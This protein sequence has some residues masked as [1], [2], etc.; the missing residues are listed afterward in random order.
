ML[1][2][3]GPPK[4]SYRKNNHINSD[5]NDKSVNLF[6]KSSFLLIIPAIASFVYNGLPTI[7]VLPIL[8]LNENNIVSFVNSFASNFVIWVNITILTII[9]HLTNL[10]VGKEY[11]VPRVFFQWLL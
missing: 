9:L 4:R 7:A 2:N 3:K 10:Q 8:S 5:L 11:Y 1:G 6:N